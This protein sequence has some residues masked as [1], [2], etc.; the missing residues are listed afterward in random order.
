[1]NACEGLDIDSMENVVLYETLK[2]N[3]KFDTYSINLN[4]CC[5]LNKANKNSLCFNFKRGFGFIQ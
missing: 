5:F 1:M 3:V 2:Q 4:C